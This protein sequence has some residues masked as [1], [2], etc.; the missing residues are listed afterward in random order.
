[1]FRGVLSNWFLISTV[2]VGCGDEHDPT[3]DPEDAMPQNQDGR[4]QCAVGRGHSAHPQQ[5]I[6]VLLVPQRHLGRLNGP[7]ART[8]SIYRRE[9]S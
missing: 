6:H 1:M 8:E 7:S 9:S 5:R 2:P 3:R 4:H